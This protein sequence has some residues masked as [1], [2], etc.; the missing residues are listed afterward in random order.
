MNRPMTI[1]GTPAMTFVRKRNTWA[2]VRVRPYSFRYTAPRMPSG[3][4]IRVAIT[5]I[6]TVPMIAAFIPGPGRRADSW[7]SFVNH[8]GNEPDTIDHPLVTTVISTRS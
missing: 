1:D 7:M 6:T 5:V 4:A 2:N 3:T 8:L